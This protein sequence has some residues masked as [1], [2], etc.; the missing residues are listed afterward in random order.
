[1]DGCSTKGSISTSSRPFARR[2]G[3]YPF[4]PDFPVTFEEKFMHYIVVGSG[5]A[6]AVLAAR[7]TEDPSI[8]VTLI[9]AGP[10]MP[11]ADRPMEMLVPN[12]SAIIRLNRFSELYQFDKLESRRTAKQAPRKYWRGRVMGGSSAING[13]IALRGMLE[14]FDDWAAEGCAGWT[15]KDVLPAFVRLENDLD[16]GDQPYHGNS[17]PIP[18]RRAPKEA[19]GAIDKALCEAA[20]ALGYGW[21]DDHNAPGATGVSPYAINNTAD[22]KRVSCADGYVE[23]ARQRSNLTIVTDTLVDSLIFEGNRPRVAGVNTVGKNGPAAFRADE[24]IICAGACHS[25]TILMRSGIGPQAVLQPL[26]IDVVREL[27]VGQNFQDHPVAGFLLELIP[28]AR[29][30]SSYHRHTNVTVR[31]S[32]G[33]GGAG[34]NDMKLI[35]L[36][37]FGDSIFRVVTPDENAS[38]QGLQGV[39]SVS[40]QQ[41]FSRGELRIVSRDPS[42]DPDI[43][44]NMLSDPRDV[45]RMRDGT[46]RLLRLASHPAMQRISIRTSGRFGPEGP[47]VL[48][49]DER[50]D[51]WLL[52]YVSD[53]QHATG[54]CRMGAADDPRSV[55]T[56]DC[57]VIGIDGLR[58]VD[59]S[60]MPNI[61]RA[62]THLSTVMVGEL[63][64]DRIVR[65]H[66]EGQAR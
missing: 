59:A 25:P 64:A 2:P 53:E 40:A 13:Q 41:C 66:R 61:P 19:W 14:D 47:E 33:L 1:M 44:E 3:A 34:T 7:L 17:G 4:H 26:G 52:N 39:V 42:Q 58:V 57:R 46:K 31:Y 51:E 63:M 50:I 21:A 23:P 20:L 38:I 8:R 15:A 62:N 9:E 55:V 24:T 12:P 43:D 48:T 45:V 16:F 37:Q 54:T 10:D 29:P 65:E 11:S 36:N 35:G 22:Q 18:I 28:E 60:I 56:P 27:P 32:S 49:S 6:G 30:A 5:S